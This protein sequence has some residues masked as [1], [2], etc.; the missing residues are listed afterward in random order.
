MITIRT[1]REEDYS[2]VRKVNELAFGQSSEAN[3]V[4]ALRERARPYISLVAADDEKI[5]GHIFFSPVMIQSD[6][7][8]FTAMGLAPMAVLPE[9]QK[10]GV[11][12]LLVREGLKECLRIGHDIVVVL[13]HAD[14][15]PRFGFVTAKQKGISSQYDVPDEHFMIAELTPNALRGRAGL[16]IYHPEFK[17]F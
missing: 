4:E 5:V 14:Y 12:S 2:D 7:D 10:Q 17:N 9:L 1:E 13:G 3:L 6:D 11:G 8:S 16:V 15:Y